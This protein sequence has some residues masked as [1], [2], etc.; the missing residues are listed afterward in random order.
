M[1]YA[2]KTN[3]KTLIPPVV[4]FATGGVLWMFEGTHTD[5][6]DFLENKFPNFYPRE[7][8][9][10]VRHGIS[11]D[12]WCHMLRRRK[13]L[14]LVT[15]PGVILD[16]GC[17]TGDLSVELA[18]RGHQVIGLDQFAPPSGNFIDEQ[19]AKT[20]A[21]RYGVPA[22]FLRGEATDLSRFASASFDYVIMGELLEHF[23][24]S[25]ILLEGVHRVLK[26]GG[27]L[28]VTVPNVA[29]LGSRWC[30]A[31]HGVFLDNWVEHR[32][33]FN[34]R[35]LERLLQKQSFEPTHITSDFVDVPR[36]GTGGSIHLGHRWVLRAL[37]CLA[38]RYPR[39]GRSLIVRCR[40][41]VSKDG[42]GSCARSEESRR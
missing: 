13:I 27:H 19:L 33:H 14:E 5:I 32:Q 22:T 7:T 41:G 30:L 17:G 15:D 36:L 26:P 35:E 39:L 42:R 40:R 4:S 31:R 24:D 1:N 11:Y 18:L 23:A 6:K 21:E 25:T 10:E 3:L 12:F 37:A 38:D 34:Q 9:P 29:S 20:L 2:G 28:L 16:L 8:S